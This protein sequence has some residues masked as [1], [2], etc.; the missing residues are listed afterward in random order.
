LKENVGEAALFAF[1]VPSDVQAIESTVAD[2]V[3][4]CRAAA[5]DGPRLTFNFRVGVTEALANAMLYGNRGDARIPVRVELLLESTRVVVRVR[6]Q[7]N[8]FDPN[9]VPDPTLQCNLERPGGRGVFLLRKLM[10]EVRYNDRGNEVQLV[11]VRTAPLRGQ[12]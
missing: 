10:D 2:M 5:F 6:D 1:D 4:R 7:G 8:G 3:E 11:L 9:S 12:S